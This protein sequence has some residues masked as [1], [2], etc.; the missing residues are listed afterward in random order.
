LI[1]L[2]WIKIL[3]QQG[4]RS[5]WLSK[6]KFPRYSLPIIK[7][8][9]NHFFLLKKVVSS[10]NSFLSNKLTWYLFRK[11]RRHQ[12][13]NYQHS[14]KQFLCHRVWSFRSLLTT[15]HLQRYQTIFF[16][17]WS[18]GILFHLFTRFANRAR[19]LSVNR[20]HSQIDYYHRY[21]YK[22]SKFLRECQQKLPHQLIETFP[23]PFYSNFSTQTFF[24]QIHYLMYQ[25]FCQFFLFLF[26]HLKVDLFKIHQTPLMSPYYYSSIFLLDGL[27]W[28]LGLTFSS[29][30]L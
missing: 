3:N 23:V 4:P 2:L 12:S 7:S 15:Y 13:L 21:H 17:L 6:Q 24:L 8:P 20:I 25:L 11:I 22:F 19:C 26:R 5:T 30:N 18:S 27:D 9:K 1:N 14:F 10:L 29:I 16:Y 28:D